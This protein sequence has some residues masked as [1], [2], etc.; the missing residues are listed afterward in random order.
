MTSSVHQVFIYFLET[1]VVLTLK[2]LPSSL[3]YTQLYTLLVSK[4]NRDY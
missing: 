2:N 1:R 4:Q 3:P